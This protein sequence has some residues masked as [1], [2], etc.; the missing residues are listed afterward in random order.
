[1]LYD[2]VLVLRWIVFRDH[3]QYIYMISNEDVCQDNIVVGYLEN[4][5]LTF[6]TRLK[7]QNVCQLNT[8]RPRISIYLFHYPA[9]TLVAQ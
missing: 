2:N 3:N 7:N 4:F 1:M 6:Q 5:D 9:K 8:R